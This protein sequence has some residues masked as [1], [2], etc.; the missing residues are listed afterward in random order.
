[1]RGAFPPTPSFF[2]SARRA[3]KGCELRGGHLGRGSGTKPGRLWSPAGRP[4]RDA[5]LRPVT[6]LAAQLLPRQTP[7]TPGPLRYPQPRAAGGTAGGRGA[8]LLPALAPQ[9]AQEAGQ[10]TPGEGPSGQSRLGG[11]CARAVHP[12]R[13]HGTHP[14][15]ESPS[16]GGSFRSSQLAPRVPTDPLGSLVRTGSAR[17]GAAGSVPDPGWRPRAGCTCNSPPCSRCCRPC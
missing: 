3:A 4:S 1:M 5:R 14:P 16:P 11:S 9:S 17:G 7:P 8:A 13:Q 2:G 10:G 12:S 15:H 6:Q